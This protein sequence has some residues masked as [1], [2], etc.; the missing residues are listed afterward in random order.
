MDYP[1]YG[2]ELMARIKVE[3]KKLQNRIDARQ[4][5]NQKARQAK[6]KR[7]E[8]KAA[9]RDSRNKKIQKKD[10][11]FQ[12]QEDARDNRHQTK[13]DDKASRSKKVKANK[14]LNQAVKEAGKDGR[15]TSKEVNQIAGNTRFNLDKITS[16][17]GNS[18]ANYNKENLNYNINRGSLTPEQFNANT[19]DLLRQYINQSIKKDPYTG[20]VRPGPMRR[21]AEKLS[22]YGVTDFEPKPIQIELAKLAQSGKG[23]NNKTLQ[24]LGSRFNIRPQALVNAANMFGLTGKGNAPLT[25]DNVRSQF[26]TANADETETTVEQVDPAE[27]AALDLEKMMEGFASIV[28]QGFQNQPDIG[29]LMEKLTNSQ[30]ALFGNM[31]NNNRIQ[32]SQMNPI[33][34]APVLG[35]RSAGTQNY[36]V[37]NATNTFGRTGSRVQ[38]I[39]NN[40]LNLT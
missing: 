26:R 35:V 39:K 7:H 10:D 12:K 13:A 19:N 24:E 1:L 21:T 22:D 9:N 4:T 3:S 30:N 17:I 8:K 20:K 27:N 31:V 40:S 32:Q 29:S 25:A 36:G 37:N 14:S 38:G 34:M 15:I 18:N 5:S 16:A 11:A 28:K 33:R 23:L 2:G 6:T